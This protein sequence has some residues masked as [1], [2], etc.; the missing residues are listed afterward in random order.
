MNRNKKT[1][2]VKVNEAIDYMGFTNSIDNLSA[3]E[4][5]TDIN[6]NNLKKTNK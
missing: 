4:N 1:K 3:G 6:N 2:N 5:K